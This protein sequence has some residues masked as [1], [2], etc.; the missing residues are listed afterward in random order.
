MKKTFIIIGLTLVIGVVGGIFIQKKI[1]KP[2]SKIAITMFEEIIKVKELHLIKH[3][4]Q[5]L[6]FIH[7]K[8]DP[9]K[10]LRAIAIIPVVVSSY[11]D[12]NDI[13]INKKND[14]IIGIVLP[15]PQLEDPNFKTDKM[16]VKSVRD[17]QIYMGKDLHSE[18]LKY[19]RENTIRRKEAIIKLSIDNG[20]INETKEDAAEYIYSLMKGLGLNQVPVIFKDELP[21]KDTV[22]VELKSFNNLNFELFS[23]S[24]SDQ[25]IVYNPEIIAVENIE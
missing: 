1:T 11:I 24:P 8:N 21:I 22:S 15:E 3:K 10:T 13:E 25:K 4:Y 18:V 6:S 7:K 12:L 17:F 2:N 14:S 5:D 20:I 19:F 23:L 16:E 9:D